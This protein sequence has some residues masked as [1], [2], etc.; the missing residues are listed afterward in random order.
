MHVHPYPVQLG[1]P[2]ATAHDRKGGAAASTPA[3]T[4]PAPETP[5]DTVTLSEAAQAA[6]ARDSETVHGKSA[7]SPAH[8]ARALLAD[9]EAA[10]GVAGNVNF[11]QLVSRV[12][13]GLDVSDLLTPP[14]APESA[15][16]DESSD[17]AGSSA[18]TTPDS[19]VATTDPSVL[20]PSPDPQSGSGI[21]DILSQSESG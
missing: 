13:R 9:F 3:A 20:V 21:L 2:S 8:Q 17:P 4:P 1:G 16:E 11:G 6:I 18:A 15:G 12:A 7:N 14:A 19:T 10:G 5:V